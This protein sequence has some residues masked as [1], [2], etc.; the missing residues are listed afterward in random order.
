MLSDSFQV[1]LEVAK[2]KSNI[3]SSKLKRLLE[4][5]QTKPIKSLIFPEIISKKC[6]LSE[7]EV[8]KIFLL[9]EK[10]GIL[11]QVYKLYCPNCKDI[12]QHIFESFNELEEQ[13]VCEECGKDLY[14]SDNPY[15]YIFVNFEV[16]RNE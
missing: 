8:V 13:S 11:K 10:L 14:D 5:I 2:Q 12:S 9:L 16:I 15:K 3:E 7:K 1:I 6:D 4:Y